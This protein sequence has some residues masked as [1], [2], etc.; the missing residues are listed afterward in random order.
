MDWAFGFNINKGLLSL[1]I[2]AQQHFNSNSKAPRKTIMK[3]PCDHNNNEIDI[4][5]G[6]ELN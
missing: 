5:F 4:E 6:F 3:I 2:Q 1:P